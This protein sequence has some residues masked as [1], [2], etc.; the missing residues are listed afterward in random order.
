MFLES[1]WLLKQFCFVEK[2]YLEFFV[3]L[4]IGNVINKAVFYFFSWVFKKLACSEKL[5]PFLHD[6]SG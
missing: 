1:P 5:L 3:Q 6:F 4:Q 2:L